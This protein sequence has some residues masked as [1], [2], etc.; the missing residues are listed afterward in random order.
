VVWA[1]NGVT[2]KHVV[3]HDHKRLRVIVLDLSAPKRKL[4]DQID[5]IARGMLLNSG[6]TVESLAAKA[7]AR[8]L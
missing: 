5:E 4:L 6:R 2:S 7:K 3:L 1:E 8:I